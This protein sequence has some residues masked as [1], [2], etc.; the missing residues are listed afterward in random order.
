M[1]GFAGQARDGLTGGCRLAR[2]DVADDND[3]D[4]KLFFTT[5]PTSSQYQ[6]PRLATILGTVFLARWSKAQMCTHPMVDL[7]RR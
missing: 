7:R 5:I 4:V 3:V 1:E 6:F 2:V